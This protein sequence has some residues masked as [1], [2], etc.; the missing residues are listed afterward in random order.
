M[1]KLLIRLLSNKQINFICFV[2]CIITIMSFI[3]KQPDLEIVMS[4]RK[5]ELNVE[6]KTNKKWSALREVKTQN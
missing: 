1:G 6:N 4:K 2:A 5:S 3:N